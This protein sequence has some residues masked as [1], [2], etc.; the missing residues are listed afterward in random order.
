MSLISGFNLYTNALY[1]DRY[2]L[3]TVDALDWPVVHSSI[4]NVGS[5]RYTGG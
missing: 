2:T 4:A 5:S 1:Q 3:N